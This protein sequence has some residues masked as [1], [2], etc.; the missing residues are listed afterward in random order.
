VS[1][2]PAVTA[3]GEIEFWMLRDTPREDAWSA[4]SD[5]KTARRLADEYLSTLRAR[6]PGAERVTD[7]LLSNFLRLGL[8]HRLLPD[9]TFIHCRRHPIDTALSIFTTNFGM[10]IDFAADRSDL[11]V[12]TR[13]YQRLM[14]HWRDV[15]PS[16]RLVE[17]D[18]EALVTDPEPNMRRIVAACGL[19]WND[20]CLTPHSNARRIETAS[21]SQARRPIYRTSVERW[22]RYEPWLGELLELAEAP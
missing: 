12:F 19:E 14:A 9:A 2:H 4:A 1:S 17:V 18:Y 15:L 11:V 20:A 5:P 3:G 16:G 8:I 21:I 10:H 13:Q 6:G 22:R 7:K